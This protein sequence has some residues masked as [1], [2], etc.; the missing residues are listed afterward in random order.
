MFQ[1]PA[2][3]ASM[4]DG[5]IESEDVASWICERLMAFGTACPTMKLMR[6]FVHVLTQQSLILGV[7][8]YSRQDSHDL[9]EAYHQTRRKCKI[10]NTQRIRKMLR[11]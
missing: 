2:C 11:R 7:V 10:S 3:A 1:L 8:T 6:A 5:N 4:I 9:V